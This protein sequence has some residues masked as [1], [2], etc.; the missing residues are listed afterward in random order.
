MFSFWNPSNTYQMQSMKS[1][2]KNIWQCKIRLYRR[3]PEADIWQIL[4][5]KS[6]YIRTILWKYLLNLKLGQSTYYIVSF[7]KP[8]LFP[9]PVLF[10]HWLLFSAISKMSAPWRQRPR[11]ICSLVYPWSPE[12]CLEQGGSSVNSSG[13]N[14]SISRATWHVTYGRG[15]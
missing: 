13:K 8:F 5:N 9:C 14:R 1:G 2:K 4:F 10:V 7:I 6:K 11:L 12:Q 15:S 3:E